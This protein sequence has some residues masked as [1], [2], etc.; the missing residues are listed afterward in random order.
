MKILL[1]L[2]NPA[3]F[4]KIIKERNVYYVY[5]VLKIFLYLILFLA[6]VIKFRS[7][8][9]S[10]DNIIK[11]NTLIFFLMILLILALFTEMLS[12]LFLYFIIARKEMK[13]KGFSKIIIPC[14]LNYI[15]LMIISVLLF[16][17]INSY[18]TRIFN[19]FASLALIYQ[20][21]T[22]MKYNEINH[23]FIKL[24]ILLTIWIL[25]IIYQTIT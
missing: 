21:F 1:A 7:V 5:Q 4:K 14:I 8:Y 23:R 17:I 9:I 16:G 19:V 12:K 20:L 24:I 10:F 22:I 3:L 18:Y 11:T 25:L 6:V 2:Y 13:Y 15:L